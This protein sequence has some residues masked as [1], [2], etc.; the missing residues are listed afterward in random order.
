MIPGLGR[1]LGA[2][3]VAA[4]PA[5]EP[6]RRPGERARA[7]LHESIGQKVLHAW[8]QNRYQTLLPLTLNLRSLAV[9]ERALVVRVVARAIAAGRRRDLHLAEAAL[10]RI[11]AGERERRMLRDALEAGEGAELFEAVQAAGLATLAYGSALLAIDQRDRVN[12]LYLA[13][14]AARLA[15]SE[16]AVAS[17]H[18]RY[19]A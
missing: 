14:L 17:L 4:E 12:Q 10:V 1:L 6:L 8:L 9:E 7:V 19:R 15:L 18:R 13:Y 5:A 3:P 2:R 11:G 16:D